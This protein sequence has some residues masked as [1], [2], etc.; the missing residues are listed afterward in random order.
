MALPRTASL[1]TPLH[2]GQ[3]AYCAWPHGRVGSRVHRLGPIHQAFAGSFDRSL[4]VLHNKTRRPPPTI[5][6][7]ARKE[8]R[9]GNESGGR[10]VASYGTNWTAHF[11]RPPRRSLLGQSDHLRCF[12]CR[13]F[14]DASNDTLTAS[15]TVIT[16]M[17]L[18]CIIASEHATSTCLQTV[19]A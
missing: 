8:E 9:R 12:R 10:T 14:Y 6:D 11:S 3:H 4:V 13:Q 19:D 7:N 1:K 16:S 5:F 17:G 2:G 15:T 18:G